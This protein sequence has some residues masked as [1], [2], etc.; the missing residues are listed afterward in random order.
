MRF[1]LPNTRREC[2]TPGK[3]H[4][5]NEYKECSSHPNKIEINPRAFGNRAIGF[6]NVHGLV[7]SQAREFSFDVVQTP[8]AHEVVKWSQ[9]RWYKIFQA[10]AHCLNQYFR[11]D[12][13]ELSAQI[14]PPR[15]I[16]TSATA[17]NAPVAMHRRDRRRRLS[18][19]KCVRLY[20]YQAIPRD[21]C[22]RQ[23]RL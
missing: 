9:L 21:N 15:A 22:S 10:N 19:W 8:K 4:T 11:K 1:R 17:S 5:E 13:E 18:K 6:L 23:Y 7:G 20:L 14:M 2:V 16:V 12:I 3:T